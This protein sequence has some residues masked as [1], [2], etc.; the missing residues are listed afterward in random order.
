MNEFLKTKN[1]HIVLGLDNKHSANI[2]FSLLI[3]ALNVTTNICLKGGKLVVVE[4]D[5]G[6]AA[7]IIGGERGII[8]DM[9]GFDKRGKRF[10]KKR[11]GQVD[12]KFLI[13]CV[14]VCV[15]VCVTA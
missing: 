5:G 8:T 3:C 4:G 12:D 14:C 7:A 9:F 2:K 1:I 15:C 10:Q 13:S 11:D 6:R